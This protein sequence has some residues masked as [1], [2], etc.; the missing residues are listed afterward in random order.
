MKKIC[1]LLL[2]IAISCNYV[3]P[4]TGIYETQDKRLSANVLDSTIYLMLSPDSA[5]IYNLKIHTQLEI[6]DTTT[7]RIYNVLYNKCLTK[8]GY[9]SF[10]VPFKFEY[11]DDF[12][13]T[14]VA[15]FENDVSFILGGFAFYKP[16]RAEIIRIFDD[17]TNLFTKNL[18]TRLWMDD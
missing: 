3:S 13:G 15:I 17:W 11:S 1:L 7:I 6:N 2:P 8:I 16:E 12:G 5:I 14:L 9:C 10:E 4:I 18:Q